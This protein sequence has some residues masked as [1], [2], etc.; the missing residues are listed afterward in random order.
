[1]SENPAEISF[2]FK[3][4]QNKY[5]QGLFAQ[6]GVAN[7]TEI[8]LGK[9]RLIYEDI[10]DTVTRDRRIAIAISPSASLSPEVSKRLSDS[11]L[12]LEVYNTQALE[13]E[14]FIDRITSHKQAEI[15]RQQLVAAGQEH[16][17]YTVTCPDC[18]ATIDLSRLDRTSYIYCRF[19]ETI[20]QENQPLMTKGAEYRVC[21]EC[22]MFDRVQGYTE[23]YFYFL[24][25]VYGFSY[26]RRH[27][28]DNCAHN[29]FLKTL[30]INLIFILGI[31][32]SIW[33]KIKSMK[34]REPALKELAKANAL[35]K[36]GKYQQA[37]PIY[38]RLHNGYPNHPG[39]L[40]DEGLAHMFGS[41]AA[42]GMERFQRSLSSCSNYYPT[43]NLLRQLQA[44]AQPTQES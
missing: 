40:L 12:M 25:V 29:V 16:L 6:K 7:E 11:T 38:Q 31:F 19:C 42:G 3:Y 8:L 37:S 18:G 36:K 33:I 14:K 2:K 10:A 13:L 4:V 32:P 43:I 26:N 30:L 44:P 22:H 15:N 23:F 24:L 17:F 5:A 9:E 28:C 1:M 21:D 39:L 27:L 35:A 20:F 34:G 41:D